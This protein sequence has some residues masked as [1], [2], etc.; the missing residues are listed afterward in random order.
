MWYLKKRERKGRRE[1][2]RE[3]GREGEEGEEVREE[4][5]RNIQERKTNRGE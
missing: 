4:G 2:G 5:G 1:E 3:E